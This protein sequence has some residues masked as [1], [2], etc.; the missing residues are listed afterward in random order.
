MGNGLGKLKCAHRCRSTCG[1]PR[2]YSVVWIKYNFHSEL[3]TLL[4]VGL[5]AVGTNASE[6]GSQVERTMYPWTDYAHFMKIMNM[7]SLYW[8]MF[9]TTVVIRLV[10]YVQHHC[11][12]PSGGLCSTPLLSSLWWFMF[13]TTVVIPLVVYVQHHCCHPSGGLCSTPLLSS[14]WWFMFNTTV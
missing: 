1:Q 9:N 11:C 2:S 4:P 12:H 7:S 13:N 6:Y 8:F 10:V 3:S 14:I 5:C